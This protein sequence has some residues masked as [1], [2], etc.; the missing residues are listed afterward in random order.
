MSTVNPLKA[1]NESLL[2]EAAEWLTRIDNGELSDRDKLALT[3]WYQSSPEHKRI[4]EAACKLKHEFSN[5]PEELSKPVLDRQ[6]LDRRSVLKSLV[7]IGL[8]IPTSWVLVKEKPWQNSLAQYKSEVGKRQTLSLEDGSELIL[9]TGTALDVKFTSTNRLIKLYEGEIF[10][11][12]GK[13]TIRP[14]SVSTDL[15]DVKALGT[16]FAIRKLSD[17]VR[18]S[19][20]WHSVQVSPSKSNISQRVNDGQACTF[21]AN[22]ISPLAKKDVNDF[23]W[24][25]GEIIVENWRIDKFIHE[26]NRYR[27]GIL[28]CDP[29]IGHLKVSGVFQTDRTD[30]ALEVL[31]GLFGLEITRYT[32]YLVS[33]KSANS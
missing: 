10:V 13:D 30:Q 14:F 15:G 16:E 18:V 9:N 6:R 23:A 5:L 7:G 28:R 32:N 22:T 17:S 4:W 2:E 31:Q 1:K 27:P 20:N 29:N 24:T 11:R 12:T 3:S 8:V 19:V 21:D 25:R 33:I 26:L